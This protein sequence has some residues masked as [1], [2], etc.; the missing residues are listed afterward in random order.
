[1]LSYTAYLCLILTHLLVYF[2]DSNPAMLDQIAAQS[3]LS[4]ETLQ[5]MCGML[6]EMS[7]EQLET[8]LKSMAKVQKYTSAVQNTWK[9]ANQVVGGK[10]K[11]ILVTVGVLLMLFVVLYLL[12]GSQ[13]SNSATAKVIEEA[14]GRTASVPPLNPHES[15]I[16][17][18]EDEFNEL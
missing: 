5:K 4:K 11:Q 3:G 12:G 17:S 10:L 8:S 14:M 2:V 18:I 1:M 16:E 7:G 6:S 13:D 9:S 15:V